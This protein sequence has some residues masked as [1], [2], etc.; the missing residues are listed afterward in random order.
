MKRISCLIA[1]IA[2]VFAFSACS[3]ITESTSGEKLCNVTFW[4]DDDDCIQEIEVNLWT[5]EYNYNYDAYSYVTGYYDYTPDCGDEYCANFYNVKE[6]YY[7]YW[8]END[9]YEWEGELRVYSS[10]H[11]INLYVAK[12]KAKSD[13]TPSAK[14]KLIQAEMN[15]DINQILNN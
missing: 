3:K 4:T 14:E 2:L 12:A 1:I 15:F 7:Y 11:T 6:G 10:C 9:Y 13:V 5:Y 8:A